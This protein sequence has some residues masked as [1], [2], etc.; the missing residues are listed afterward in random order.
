MEA[1]FYVFS[2]LFSLSLHLFHFPLQLYHKSGEYHKQIT[3]AYFSSMSC[4]LAVCLKCIVCV[5]VRG[6]LAGFRPGS[7]RWS[8]SCPTGS[9]SVRQEQIQPGGERQTANGQS[10]A[11]HKT[12]PVCVSLH[13]AISTHAHARWCDQT[14]VQS[15]L[16]FIVACEAAGDCVRSRRPSPSVWLTNWHMTG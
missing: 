6:A 3:L 12:W 15:L 4:L 13:S 5:C 8:H 14:T 16:T 1:G 2:T 11:W 9:G 7:V 10:R